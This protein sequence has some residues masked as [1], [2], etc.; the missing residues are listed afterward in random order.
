[1]AAYLFPYLPG[2]CPQRLQIGI[3]WCYA[4]EAVFSWFKCHSQTVLP[5]PDPSE[6]H[7]VCGCIEVWK[8]KVNLLTSC[9]WYKLETVSL[10]EEIFTAKNTNFC[11]RN[12]IIWSNITFFC[13]KCEDKKKI[14][15]IPVLN[16]VSRGQWKKV[17]GWCDAPQLQIKK[18]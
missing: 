9:C 3:L 15:C 16:W 12:Y 5:H 10:T 4:L 13:L 1:M 18:H 14:R 6:I 11:Q 2:M 7:T 8:N 17:K